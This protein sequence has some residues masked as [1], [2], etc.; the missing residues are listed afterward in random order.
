MPHR[1]A[2][3][4][5]LSLGPVLGILAV[6]LSSILGLVLLSYAWTLG[7]LP[8]GVWPSRS[9]AG[10]A[11]PVLAL[12]LPAALVLAVGFLIARIRWKAA[13]ATADWGP[14]GPSSPAGTTVHP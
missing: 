2:D 8:G 4:P 12:V 7:T 5:S 6:L 13:P 14:T 3:T 11:G 1:E 10:P 9:L